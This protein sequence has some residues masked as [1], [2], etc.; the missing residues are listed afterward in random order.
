MMALN[1]VQFKRCLKPRNAIGKLNLNDGKFG[2]QFVAAK[3]RVAPLNELSIP[4]L[5]LQSRRDWKPP[6]KFY[7]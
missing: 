5:E 7:P 4:G 2:V 3:S 1:S 6:R